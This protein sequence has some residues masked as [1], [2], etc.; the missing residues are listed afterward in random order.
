VASLEATEQQ[1]KGDDFDSD[2]DGMRCPCGC[3]RGGTTVATA[4]LVARSHDL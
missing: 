1:Q 2:S 3:E 4:P